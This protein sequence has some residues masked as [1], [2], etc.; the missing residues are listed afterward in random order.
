[1]EKQEKE[2]RYKILSID[3]NF[4]LELINGLYNAD[5]FN[6]IRLPSLAGILP[7]D[8]HVEAIMYDFPR[9]AF[10][11]KV[12]S[13]EYPEIMDGALIPMISSVSFDFITIELVNVEDGEME[14]RT[15]QQ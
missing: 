13:K 1:M 5:Q 15:K 11:F 8:Y 4:I 14:W 2:H 10:S 6:T 9:S 7:D 12:Y 3:Q